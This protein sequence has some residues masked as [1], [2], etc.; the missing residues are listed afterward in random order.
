MSSYSTKDLD[1]V[2]L[3]EVEI[4]FGDMERTSGYL[5]GLINK[6]QN[7]I[8]IRELKLARAKIQEVGFWLK[9]AL[10]VNNR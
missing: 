5:H 2:S 6:N 4:M 3:E 8:C 1:K 10:E 9:R 7:A